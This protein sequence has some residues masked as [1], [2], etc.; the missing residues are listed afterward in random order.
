MRR[1]RIAQLGADTQEK[2]RRMALEIQAKSLMYALIMQ[3]VER[4]D[5]MN[6]SERSQAFVR[7]LRRHDAALASCQ[8]GS[9]SLV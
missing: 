2:M 1:Q 9:L 7:A 5:N 4:W 6:S 3:D 8:Q